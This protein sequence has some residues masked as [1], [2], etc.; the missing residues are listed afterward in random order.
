MRPGKECTMDTDGSRCGGQRGRTLHSRAA[1]TLVEVMIALMI[2]TVVGG[3]MVT[4]LLLATDI[5]R[6]GEFSRGANDEAIA[7]MGA[8]NQDL[9]HLIPPSAGGWCY[10]STMDEAGGCL[11]AFT[12]SLDTSVRLND[13]FTG[14]EQTNRSSRSANQGSINQ[15]AIDAGNVSSRQIV[16][17]WVNDKERTLYRDTL[18]WDPQA[19]TPDEMYNRIRS[20]AGN[21]GGS[22]TSKVAVTYGCLH[23]GAWLSFDSIDQNNYPRRIDMTQWESTGQRLPPKKSTPYDSAPQGSSTPGS[24]IQPPP[25]PQALRLSLAL[26]GGTLDG[27]GKYA[28]QGRVIDDDGRENLRVSG[29]KGLPVADGSNFL[30]IDNEWLRYDTLSGVRIHVAERGAR[31]SLSSK[32]GR[33]AVAEIGLQYSLVRSLGR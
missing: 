11:V 32:H 8:L 18:A 9:D 29:F 14:V 2:F 27:G 6:R 31:R 28:P 1:M 10:A 22:L 26:T 3:A 33:G 21:P 16:A 12:I 24:G 25:A 23:F 7:V 19:Q 5:Y 13:N 30:R 20:L 15:G 17:W 4:I